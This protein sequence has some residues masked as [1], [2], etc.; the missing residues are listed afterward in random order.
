MINSD[1]T[2]NSFESWCHK[3]N[4]YDFLE[5]WDSE[6][7]GNNSPATVAKGSH[8]KYHW[9]CKSCG[10]RYLRAPHDFT[11]NGEN[12]CPKCT[13]VRRGIARHNAAVQKH[14]L[15]FNYPE[16][17]QEWIKE[18][19][20]NID[21]SEVAYTDNRKFWWKCSICGTEW[22][23][24][25]TNRVNGTGCPRC[26]SVYHS[27]FP[28]RAIFYYV[29]K[30]FSD[31]VINDKRF[32]F[33]LDIYIPSKKTGI[34]YDGQQWHQD[35]KKDEEKNRKCRL[36]GIVLFRIRE[37]ECWFWSEDPF[38]HLIASATQNDSE[39]N[40]AI[41]VL[42]LNLNVAFA[43]VDVQRDRNQ[44]LG[45]YLNAKQNNSIAVKYPELAQEFDLVKNAPL[46]PERVDFGSGIMCSWICSKCGYSFLATP[47]S[48][49]CKGSGCP[50]CAHLVAW[51]G[52]TDLF[53]TNPELRDEWDYEKNSSIGLMPEQLL[54]GSE[55]QAFWKCK[56]GHS[57]KTAIV[58]RKIG[59]GCP[60]CAREKRCIR[61]INLDT[62]AVFSSIK[63][64][65][66]WC[67]INSAR[68]SEVCKGKKETAGG[69][70]WSYYRGEMEASED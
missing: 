31:A 49:T 19:N 3:T 40:N 56:N 16:L 26:K 39:L 52:H 24:A 25:I 53:T 20:N 46:T 54:A 62:G 17:A 33:E 64:A 9:I 55:K 12:G 45:T 23:A 43:D 59:H 30:Y 68:I 69:F 48:R 34:E 42:L 6:L 58:N 61:V 5:C 14:N 21:S 18:K 22:E 38:L 70:H 50:S 37:R 44:I 28:E 63:E 36:N 57:W 66:I 8:I 10:T 47:N 29:S 35:K 4:H 65:S 2:D 7:N 51:E 1:H 15:K 67:G 27:S 11:E 13:I 41:S 60:I 32:G